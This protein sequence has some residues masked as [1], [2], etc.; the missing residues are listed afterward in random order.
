MN[1]KEPEIKNLDNEEAIV[2]MKE[3]VTRN[4]ICM[5][6]TLI[7]QFPLRTRPMDALDVCDQGNFWFLSVED[8]SKNVEIRMDERVQL[9]FA[10]T[11]ALEYL[12]VYGKA[13]IE[14]KREKI[15]ELWKPRVNVWFP[16]GK[17]DMKITVLKI[18]P[19]EVFYWSQK[20]GKMISVL[21]VIASATGIVAD[22]SVSGKLNI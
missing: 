4:S 15:E 16:G 9:F 17:N 1:T 2:K 12:S 13:S 20:S 21:K 6:T 18:T 3:I 5:F 19:Q 14:T 11:P 10:N 7:D 22:F 8:S